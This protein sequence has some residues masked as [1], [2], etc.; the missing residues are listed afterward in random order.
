MKMGSFLC[1][2]YPTSLQFD[3]DAQFLFAGDSTGSILLLRLVDNVA[4]LFT[5]LSAHTGSISDLAWDATRQL[6]F[7]SSSDSLVIVWDIGSK[8]G[9][10]YELTGHSTKLTALAY[11]SG[12]SKLFS[13]DENG[14]LLC[15]DMKAKR[16]E[17]P[18]WKTADTCQLCDAPFFW[19]FKVMWERKVVGQR[20]HHCR[21][22]GNA[23]CSACAANTTRFPPM[24][25]E[26]PVRICKACH[27]RMTDR[28]DEFDLTPLA[29]STDL[30][31]GV[32][33]MHLDETSGR[34]VTVGFD[35]VIMIWDIKRFC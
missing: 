10:A 35:R 6:L 21:T 31:I 19:N 16:I 32:S 27:Q 2:S 34:L 13:A 8:K 9:Q 14:M 3:A 30:R 1:D 22:C 5:K 33:C 28:P 26:I 12:S 25:Y 24:G 18:E 4:Q 7:S 23:I 29:S 17:T 15:W 11:A 20:Q